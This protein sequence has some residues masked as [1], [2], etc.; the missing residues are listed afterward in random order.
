MG[1]VGDQVIRKRF[2][3]HP[4]HVDQLVA[5]PSK[6]ARVHFGL[7]MH[8]VSFLRPSGSRESAGMK[9]STKEVTMGSAAEPFRMHVGPEQRV[10]FLRPSGCCSEATATSCAISALRSSA[11]AFGL[12][13]KVHP[14]H[15]H[16]QTEGSCTVSRNEKLSLELEGA[17]NAAGTAKVKAA[18]MAA[19]YIIIF[20]IIVLSLC[21]G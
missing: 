14:F 7:L 4:V 21:C 17:A 13:P 16:E 18:T 5:E 9:L 1:G 15:L 6:L 10:G 3:D 2:L 20:L 8:R 11:S 12:Q 19:R